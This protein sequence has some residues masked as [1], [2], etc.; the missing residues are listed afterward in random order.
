MLE[1]NYFNSFFFLRQYDNQPVLW[2]F[3][4]WNPVLLES[5]INPLQQKAVVN[6]SSL[7]FQGGDPK[8]IKPNHK[9]IEKQY[10]PEV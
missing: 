1:S 5:Q 3:V 8:T 4:V 9:A 2:I 7:K 6:F 10:P